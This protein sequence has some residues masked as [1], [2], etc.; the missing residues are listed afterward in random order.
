MNINPGPPVVSAALGVLLV[1][2]SPP[3]FA[4]ERLT[5]GQYDFAMTTEGATRKFSQCITPA[6]AAEVNGDTASGR[7][8]AEKAANGRCK[9]D[10]YEAADDKVS[11]TLTCGDHVIRS[12]TTFHGDSSEGSVVTTAEGKT[13]TAQVSAHRVGACR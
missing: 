3:M 4:A 13:T 11:Y 5:S 10:A 8:L 12:V 6:K 2:M 1:A 9:V 7:A